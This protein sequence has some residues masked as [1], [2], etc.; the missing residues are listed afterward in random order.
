MTSSPSQGF[1]DKRKPKESYFGGD[2]LIT[3]NSWTDGTTAPEEGEFLHDYTPPG[4]RSHSP[5]TGR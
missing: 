3:T 4:G 5:T 2:V 1:Y